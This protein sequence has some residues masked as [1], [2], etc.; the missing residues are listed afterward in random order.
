MLRHVINAWGTPTPYGVSRSDAAV[1]QAVAQ[2]LQRHVFMSELQEA[3]GRA[4]VAWTGAEAACVT[5]CTASAITL[6]VAACM[7]GQ[8][9]SR[10]ARL[11]DA[12]GLPRTVLMLANH[13]VHYGH[14]LEQAVRL[15]GAQPVLADTIDALQRAAREGGVACVLA[16]ES[17]LASSSGSQQTTQLL[18]LAR[19]IGVPLVLDAAAQDW[20][21]AE[22]VAS[23]ADLVLLSAQKHLRSPTAG[24]V[25][26]R[27][28][29]V[30]AVDAQHR[31]IGRAMKPT[32]EAL[33][34]VMAALECRAGLSL[35]DWQVAQHRKVDFVAQAAAS[36]PGVRVQREADP[37][38]GGFD[39]LWLAVD[40]EVC[41]VDATGLVQRLR[42][43]D[44]VI[45]VAPHR[46]AQG[47]IGLEFSG[48]DDDE[49]PALCS[50]L[51]QAL[52]GDPGGL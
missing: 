48:V 51:A 52:R 31:G 23:G 32:K 22:L 33:A 34:G 10:I 6:S 50:S 45:A 35:A 43:G 46:V 8:D 30:A 5:H 11:P 24:L 44:P 18:A 36:W 1:A 2:M 25:L 38:G 15:A 7:A 26:G 27:T 4:L 40:P 3:V 28:A 39:R 12:Q 14:A 16:V 41:A 42:A 13:Q 17:Q 19:N 37:L 9:A 20:R 47:L 49:L 21:A 29:L